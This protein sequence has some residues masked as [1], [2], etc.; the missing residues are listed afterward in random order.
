MQGRELVSFQFLIRS[1]L[2]ILPKEFFVVFA[3]FVVSSW[4]LNAIAT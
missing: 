4:Y 1:I 2:L 3:V